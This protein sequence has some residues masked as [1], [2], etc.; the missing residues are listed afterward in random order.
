MLNQERL[1]F[2]GGVLADE[3][4]M[5]KTLQVTRRLDRCYFREN[6]SGGV[7]YIYLFCFYGLKVWYLFQCFLSVVHF[8]DYVSSLCYRTIRCPRLKTQK[9]GGQICGLLPDVI[10]L[11]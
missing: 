5:G 10:V 1:P 7:S 2:K 11:Q 3:M 8:F 9:Q 6:S 4:G